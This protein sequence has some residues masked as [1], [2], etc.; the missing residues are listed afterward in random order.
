MP[1]LIASPGSGSGKTSIA[2]GLVRA[3]TLRGLRVAVAKTGP[4]YL[5][6]TWLSAAAGRPCYN[7][8]S[9]MHTPAQ[10]KRLAQRIASD[11]D[12]LLIEGAMGL[13]D[14]PHPDRLEGSAAHIAKILGAHVV[15]VASAQS[16]ARS[17][18]ALAKGFCEFDRT[19]SVSAII[20]NR[21]GSQRHAD[22]LKKAVATAGLP[23]LVGCIPS[24]GLPELGSRHLGL[25]AAST[26]AEK[27]ITGLAEVCEQH[28]NLDALVALC[29]PKSKRILAPPAKSLPTPQVRWAIAR[30]EAFSF[31]YQETLDAF[32]AAGIELISCSPLKDHTLPV[33][34]DGLY[35]G[36]GYPESHAETLSENRS[37]L[38][39]MRRFAKNGGKIHAECG[40]LMYLAKAIRTKTGRFPLCGILPVE[41]Q[42]NERCRRLGYVEVRTQIPTVL[43]PKGQRVRG[44]EFHYS[45]IRDL[46]PL[47]KHGW[48]PAYR[49]RYRN[50]ETGEEGWTKGNITASYVHLALS[51]I[52]LNCKE[53]TSGNI[54]AL[55]S[56]FGLR[57]H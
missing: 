19:V 53:N 21:V 49:L 42:Q 26:D 54:H 29:Q 10:V 40:G 34:I 30:D 39:S 47:K 17:F 57:R 37:F 13:F 56:D 31:Y 44:H 32:A 5:D 51:R 7:F 48:I 55:C 41:I 20:A 2:T 36:G 25:M 33:N 27:T 6:P 3:L 4:D 43:V 23:P 22:I 1:L 28:I 35:L 15:L 16:Q 46:K 18:A 12:I 24:G 9:W 50:G 11:A 8:D 38:S 45:E 14:G 52:R